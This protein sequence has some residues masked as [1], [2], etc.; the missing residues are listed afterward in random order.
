MRGK[1]AEIN[2]IASSE[3]DVVTVSRPCFK[4]F[5]ITAHPN[6]GDNPLTIFENISNFITE[7]KAKIIAQDVFGSCE[8]HDKGIKTLE[9]LCGKINWPVTWIEGNGSYG[10]KLTGTQI[11]AVS[12]GNVKPIKMDGQIIG[13][14]FED[15]D[16]H[17]CFLGDLRPTDTTKSNTEQ[18]LTTF[19]KIEKALELADMDFSHVIRTWMYLD[20]L[21]SWY[22]EFNE[23]R[24][25]FFKDSGVSNKSIPASTGIG[26]ANP[27]GAALVTDVLALKPKNENIKAFAVPSPLQCPAVD[28]KSSFSRATEV[29]LS[30]HRRLYISGTASIDPEGATVYVGDVKKQITLTMKVVQ[31]ILQSRNMNWGDVSR[32]IAYFK[33]MEDSSLLEQY[34]RGN[35]LP[36]MPIAVAHGD[37]CRDDLLFEIEVDAVQIHPY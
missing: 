13:N 5:Y 22:D 29:V 1:F 35:D 37:I 7:H 15:D 26:V 24:N 16:A 14:T 8:L 23:V 30:D 20:N 28:Y 10:K 21:L 6:N 19:K 17:Y 33:D 3:L 32:A 2:K 12:D 34:C 25:N 11:Y 9:N 27:D 18:A 36:H 4:K 31:A